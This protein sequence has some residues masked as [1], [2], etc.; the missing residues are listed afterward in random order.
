MNDSIAETAGLK[1][2]VMSTKSATPPIATAAA[3]CLM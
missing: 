1:Y 3:D 2:G